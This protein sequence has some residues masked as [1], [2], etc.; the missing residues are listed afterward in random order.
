[1][2]FWLDLGFSSG[3]KKE[4]TVN[5]LLRYVNVTASFNVPRL[6][7]L[8]LFVFFPVFLSEIVRN[9]HRKC[10]KMLTNSSIVHRLLLLNNFR[11][12]YR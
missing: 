7:S 12:Q 4:L 1:M 8:F 6:T 2:K 10:Y 9:F 5:N 3:Y 11:P